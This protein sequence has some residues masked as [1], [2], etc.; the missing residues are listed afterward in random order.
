M[1]GPLT[2]MR[3]SGSRLQPVV[4]VDDHDLVGDVLVMALR[5]RGLNAQ[6]LRVRSAEQ[7]LRVLAGAVE[8]V[9]G[10]ALLDLDLGCGV[11]GAPIDGATLVEPLRRSGW[12]VVV[13]TGMRDQSRIAAAVAAGATGLVQKSGSLDEL[14]LAAIAAVEGRDLIC[15]DKRRHWEQLHERRSAARARR[16]ELLGRLTVRENEVLGL[17]AKGLRV[18]GV[19]RQLE[20]SEATVRTQVKSILRKL[21]VNSQIEALATYRGDLAD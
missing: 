10:V 3:A 9:R 20:L 6:R 15:P 7:V 17:L 2:S 18:G 1:S 14:V 16:D 5:K 4:V 19:A 12:Q 13:V 8:V 21:G 11:D